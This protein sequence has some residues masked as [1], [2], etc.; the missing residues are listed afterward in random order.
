MLLYVGGTF[1]HS[2]QFSLRYLLN[3]K[4]ILEGQVC[5]LNH[6]PGLERLRQED[7]ELKV[8]MVYIGRLYLKQNYICI[9]SHYSDLKLMEGPGT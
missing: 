9:G 4:D 2:G 5:W 1:L 7:C 3:I 8:S 6:D